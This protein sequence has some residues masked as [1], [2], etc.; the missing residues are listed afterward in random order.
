[1]IFAH[2]RGRARKRKTGAFGEI[3]R[4]NCTNFA[5]KGSS[6]AKTH[7]KSNI[8]G[9]EEAQH[10]DQFLRHTVRFDADALVRIFG[11]IKNTPEGF[12]HGGVCL[13]QAVVR[14]TA[15][16]LQKYSQPVS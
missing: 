12:P 15:Y 9:G 1:M 8:V 3:R 7:P 4:R 13:N 2:S 10:R 6:P 16:K 11:F 5:L 14:A